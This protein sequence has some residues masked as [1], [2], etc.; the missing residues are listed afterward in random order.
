MGPLLV[1]KRQESRL[2]GGWRGVPT[3]TGFEQLEHTSILGTDGARAILPF[4]LRWGLA[5]WS[6]VQETLELRLNHAQSWIG[7]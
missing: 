3:R 2:S 6:G 5:R 7:S 1:A 4:P